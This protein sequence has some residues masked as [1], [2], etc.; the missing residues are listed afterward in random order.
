VDVDDLRALVVLAREKRFTLAA[1]AIGASQ[2][3]LS[4]RIQALERAVGTKL[5][6]RSPSGV[7]LTESGE[8]LLAHVERA[9]SSLDS[10]LTELAEL[11]GVPK[12]QVAVGTL[13]TVSA[14]M[15]PPI[16]AR[17]HRAHPDVRILLREGFSEPL[18]ALVARGELD[19]AIVHHPVRREELSARRLF[20]EDYVLAVPPRHPVARAKKPVTLA[21]VATE[22]F[23]VIPGAPAMAAIERACAER[24]VR[25]VVALESENLESVRRM[26]EAGLGIALVP[27]MM[28]RDRRRWRARLVDLV[29]GSVTREIALVHRGQG[30]LGAAARALR[31]AVI[32]AARANAKA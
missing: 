30:Y 21:S 32:E 22:P 14:Y 24:G 25:P 16:L 13:P 29:P 26:V 8:R 10:G 31:E 27:R 3:T 19:M 15:L 18:Q 20:R 7:V 12:G 6:V 4:R 9:L 28:T 1:R 2:P 5:L 11:Q 23:V 17:F